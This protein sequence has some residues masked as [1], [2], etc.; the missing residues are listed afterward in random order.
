MTNIPHDPGLDNSLTLLKEGYT[1]IASRCE[2]YQSDIFTTR[3]IAT[4]AYCV[5][6]ED[7]ARMFYEPGRFTRQGA[8]PPTTRCGSARRNSLPC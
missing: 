7:A 6:G 3:L 2:R 8:M 4:R 5:M 1:F